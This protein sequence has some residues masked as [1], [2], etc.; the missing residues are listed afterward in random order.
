MYLLS[1]AK[2]NEQLGKVRNSQLGDSCKIIDQQRLGSR[3]SITGTSSQKQRTAAHK[4]SY[5]NW[6]EWK[7]FYILSF[8]ND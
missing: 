5:D 1:E 8:I 4:Q 3:M 2:R 6:N 7:R